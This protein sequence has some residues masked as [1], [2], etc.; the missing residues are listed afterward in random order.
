[1]QHHAWFETEGFEN[2]VPLREGN[3]GGIFNGEGNASKLKIID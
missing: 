2:V 1:M 3:S